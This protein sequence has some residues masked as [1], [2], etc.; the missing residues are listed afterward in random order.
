MPWWSITGVLGERPGS[1]DFGGFA[2]DV[3]EPGAGPRSVGTTHSTYFDRGTVS[4]EEL[5][6]LIADTE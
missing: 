2:V 5:G 6:R 4:L 3:T 1:G